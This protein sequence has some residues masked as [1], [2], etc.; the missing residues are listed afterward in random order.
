M[1]IFYLSESSINDYVV[2]QEKKTREQ[3]AREKFKKKYNFKPDKPGS[4]TG[5]ITKD[6]KTYKVDIGKSKKVKIHDLTGEKTIA[7]RRLQADIA[8]KD[9]S[10]ILDDRYFKLKGSNHGKRRDAMLSHEIGHQNLHNVNSD[11]KTVD[12]KNRSHSVYASTLHATL[13]DSNNPYSEEDIKKS[14]KAQNF[15]KDNLGS[16]EE[17]KRRDKAL[18]A[19]KKY[20]KNKEHHNAVEYEAD[21]YAANHTSEKDVKR[22]IRNTYKM[23]KQDDRKIIKSAKANPQK[24]FPTSSRKNAEKEID[25]IARKTNSNN[26]SDM[27]QRSKALKDE[28]L[29]KSD[30]Y[31]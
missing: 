9:S 13:K 16:A 3:Y 27:N 17:Q 1:G 15:D 26:Q 29:R 14:L 6:G 31:K 11:N 10:I 19:A 5:T 28:E 8:D 23:Y 2:L 22:G 7:D 12:K 24:Y 4:D 25:K 18:Q 21:R 20:E 30:V